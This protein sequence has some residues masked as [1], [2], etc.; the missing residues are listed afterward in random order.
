M[1][2]RRGEGLIGLGAFAVEASDLE[3]SY[4]NA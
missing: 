3:H 2:E 1:K 4:E